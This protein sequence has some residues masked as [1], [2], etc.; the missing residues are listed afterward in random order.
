[1]KKEKETKVTYQSAIDE[2]VD[3]FPAQRKTWYR[4]KYGPVFDYLNDETKSLAYRYYQLVSNKVSEGNMSSWDWKWYQKTE[5]EAARE[6]KQCLEALKEI[7]K[8][9]EED[10][11][12]LIKKCCRLG[13]VFLKN[14][15]I[16]LQLIQSAKEAAEN[17]ESKINF[18]GIEFG[19]EKIP[20]SNLINLVGKQSEITIDTESKDI[21]YSDL[22]KIVENF[23]D[24]EI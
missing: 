17:N 3:N 21:K 18:R 4:H 9:P 14:K 15:A 19:V 1:M 11:V 2:I 24:M 8:L 10:G 20:C 23:T 5:E 12:N 13:P 6:E 22:Q 16:I 7:E